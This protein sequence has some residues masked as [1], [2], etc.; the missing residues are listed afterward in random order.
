MTELQKHLEGLY[1]LHLASLKL[2]HGVREAKNTTAIFQRYEP[3]HFVYAF[4]VFNSLYSLNWEES[5]LHNGRNEWGK[6]DERKKINAAI[7]FCCSEEGR[8]AKLCEQ[9]SVSLQASNIE[10]LSKLKTSNN[11]EKA[12]AGDFQRSV[13]LLTEHKTLTVHS[14]KAILGLVYLVRCNVFHGR[15]TTLE[16]S[17]EDQRQRFDIYTLI[18]TVFNQHL[19]DVAAERTMWRNVGDDVYM[20]AWG[21][22]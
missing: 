21:M 11:E 1:K 19:F 3:T 15:K 8:R 16:M 14:I 13:K 9:L 22:R 7:D 2:E 20:G 18:L 4:F 5:L 17:Q 10:A 6:K 12:S